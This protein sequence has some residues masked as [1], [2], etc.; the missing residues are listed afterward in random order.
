MCEG[1]AFIAKLDTTKS[2]AAG[3]DYFTYLGG[4][5]ADTGLGIALDPSLNVYI[6][7]SANSQDFP[8]TY[9]VF[10]S[11]YGGGNSD[12]FVSKLNPAGTGTSDLVYSTYLGGSNTDTGTSIAVDVNGDAFVAGQ[13]CSADFPLSNPLQPVYGGNC[14][15]FASE[16]VITVGISLSPAGLIF[17]P[18]ATNATSAPLTVTLSNGDATLTI[19]SITLTGAD[20]SDFAFTDNCGSTV[21]ANAQCT[22][23]VTFT[24]TVA[25]TLTADLTIVDSAPGSPQLVSLSGTATPSAVA[26][27]T[28]TTLTFGNQPIN[29][30]SP[31]QTIHLTN[32]G[33]AALTVSNLT[34]SGDFSETNNCTV[35]L[36]PTTDCVI[37]VTYTPLVPGPS[38]GAVTITD[39]APTSPQIVLV[40]GNGIQQASAIL[41]P[42]VLAFATQT[43]NTTSAPQVVTL[44]NSGSQSLSIT[45]I[46]ASAGFGE[47]NTCGTTLAIAASCSINVTFTPTAA[48]IVTGA[49]TL[50]DNAPNSPQTITLSGTGQLAPLVTLSPAS[51]TFSNQN[52]GTT[53]TPQTL[54]MTNSGSAT[55]T[56]TSIAATGNFAQTN[57][58]GS[59]LA[60]LASCTISVTFSP[61]SAGTLY[62]S[63]TITDNASNS[64]QTEVLEGVGVAV[65]AVTLTPGSLTFATQTVNTTSPAQA[66]QL[67]NTGSAALSI[68]SITASSSFAATN[69]CGTSLAVNAICVISVTFT[70]T[71]A[72]VVTGSVTIVDNAPNPNSQQTITLS[73]T[74]QLAPLVSLAPASITFSNQNVGTTST[75]QT[76]TM[77]NS[78]TAALTIASIAATGNF[79]QTNNCG[80]SLAAAASCAINVTFSPTSPGTLY[81]SVTITDNAFNS[82]QTEVLEGV[83][84]ATPAATVSASSLTF[85]SQ[86]VSTTS[87]VQTVQLQ[88]T[89]SSTLSITSITASSGFAATNTCGTSLAVNATCVINVTFSPTAAGTVGGSVTIVDNA[90]NSPQTIALTGTGQLAPLVTLSPASITFGNQNVGTASAPQT[91]TLTNSGSAALTIGLIQTTGNFAQT[92]NCGA[93]LAVSA[94]CTVNV[95]FSPAQPGNLYGTISIT[96]N[97]FNSPQTEILAGVGI[98]VPAV[99]A[100]PASL[101]FGSQQVSTTS[102][103]QTVSLQNTGSAALT[104]TSIT[105]TSGYAEA[106]TCG[107][108]LA[109]NATCVI[110]VTF[111]P[112]TSGTVNGALTITDNAVNSPQVIALTGSGELV[113]LVSLSPLNLT[114]GSTQSPQNIGSTS[115]PQTVTLTDVGSAP[116]VITSVTPTGDFAETNTCGASVAA[117]KSCTISVTF[118]P[119]APGNRYGTVTITDNASNSP[120]T[121]QLAGVGESAPLVN[122]TPTN[123]NLA[124]RPSARRARLRPFKSRTLARRR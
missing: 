87:A 11:T 16:V 92:N 31:A 36:Q 34:A 96:D 14:D 49:V 75:A 22:F 63:V 1:D 101:S 55:M 119:T 80:S 60:A 116:L 38:T 20:P 89:G 118:S 123:L 46:S 91:L 111:S 79:A 98:A 100:T 59:S 112:A 33:T 52:V 9:A 66:V 50:T 56:I 30:A 105:T 74:G 28:P 57:N 121:L 114:F 97:A 88:N 109:V 19:N 8:V 72:G 106:N 2:G 104:I 43:V 77:T 32:T 58:C 70:P 53:S 117:G 39:N 67:Q 10:Q 82:P 29:V 7:G 40:T 24:P 13:T 5:N 85:S 94:S 73:G 81:G 69:T 48:G 107:A 35:P 99:T 71:T 25:G 95:T 54:T 62:G 110:S 4:S 61:T 51:I 12:A 17:P 90:S 78:G 18:Q 103:A 45:S 41:S 15:A 21:A 47:T 68:T 84:V 26:T 23:S 120:Q 86:T 44:T 6:T 37:N 64:P 108:S 124:A 102:A 115:A 83:G 93:S 113:P 3:L 27:L 76:L 65:P 122:V 42:T